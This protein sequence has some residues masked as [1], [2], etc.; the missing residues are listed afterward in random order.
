V[1]FFFN[2]EYLDQ[3]QALSI[4]TTDPAFTAL[5]NTYGSPYSSQQISGRVDYH[6]NDKNNLFIRYS[7]DGNSGFGQALEFG[8]PSNWAHN[9]N[10]ADQGIIGVTTAVRPTIVNDARFQYNYW[11]NHNLQA[12]PSD[13]TQPCVAGTLPSVFILQGGNF[14]A[15]GP[16][17]DA[18]QTRNTRRYEFVDVLSWQK[19]AHR[20]K[21]GGDL[22]PTNSAGAWGFCTPMC[23]GAYSPTFLQNTFGSA[24]SALQPI[25]FPTVP[26]KLTSDAQVVN[27]PVL[28]IGAS[29]FSGV[30]VGS[31]STPGAYAYNENRHYD[32]WR[33]Y[34]QDVWKVSS[35][36]T[37]NY[38]LGWNAQTGF[39]PQGVNLP[40]YLAPILGANNLS[41]T[42]NNLKEFQPAGGFAWS[43]F[44]DNKTVIR[45]GAGIYWDS[46]PGYYKL[47][48]AA[49]IYPPGAARNTLAASAFTNDIAGPFGGSGVLALGGSTSTCPIPGLPCSVLPMGAPIPLNALTTMTVGQFENLVNAELPSVEAVLSPVNPQRSGPFPYPN[50]NYA[51]QGVEI[52]PENY[53]L[54]RSYQTSLGVQREVGHDIVISADWAR[55]QGENVALGEIDQN[56]FTRYQ[57]SATPVPV[58]PYCPSVGHPIPDFNPADQCSIGSITIWTPEGRALYNGLLVKANKR[59][60]NRYQFQVSYALQKGEDETVWNN[61]N[62]MAGYGQYLPH[63]Q[64]QISGTVN[65]PVGFVLSLNS[66]IITTTPTTPNVPNLILPGTVP[67]GSTEPLPGVAYGSLN[68]GTSHSGLAAAVA[69][70][71]SN[72]VGTVNAQ[73]GKISP[74]LALPQN[75]AFGTPFITQDFRLTKTFNVKEHKFSVFA[76]M[77]NA[78]N[79]ANL[80]GYS[81]TLDTASTPNAVCQQGSVLPGTAN[82]VPCNFGQPTQRINQTFGSG[83][84][85]ALQLGARFTF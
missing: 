59:F 16:N 27:L 48:A 76:E 56:L 43:P 7:H 62:W 60:S 50:I 61:V 4:Q 21:F 63:H 40:Q 64:L 23:V 70:Y 39:Y 24:Y 66:A 71:N 35:K 30:G 79:V 51:K 1:F 69:A 5:Q 6:V 29:I 75:Y 46:T 67:F 57:G 32:Q 31:P 20:L 17:F 44:K 11:S 54:A 28:N 36:L 33:V 22:N 38:G 12:V 3:V 14:P 55:R 42:R 37:F 82:S 68:A 2:Y 47:R 8:D 81:F 34:F 84:P 80:T 49:S 53:P 58:I 85:R 15:I 74:Y 83:G 13:C 18:P 52:Y 25:L 77:F 10:W 9:I 72:V 73:G 78:F 41:Q 19:G 26:N 45:G 65:L